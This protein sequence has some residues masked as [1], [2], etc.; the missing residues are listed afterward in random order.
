[1]GAGE[2]VPASEIVFHRE[3]IHLQTQDL[4]IPAPMV[5]D[6][7]RQFTQGAYGRHLESTEDAV[8]LAQMENEGKLRVH[9]FTER[10]EL[11][12]LAEPVKNAYAKEIGAEVVLARVNAVE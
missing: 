10:E 3:K 9:K 12:R 5:L 7:G 6:Q 8:R 1:M 2:E 4:R 11:L